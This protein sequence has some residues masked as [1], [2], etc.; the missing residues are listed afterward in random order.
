MEANA[1]NFSMKIIN[2]NSKLNS[3]LYVT[4]PIPCILVVF[5]F[6][7]RS[8]DVLCAYT[9]PHYLQKQY[10]SCWCMYITILLLTSVINYLS[11][12]PHYNTRELIYSKDED[13]ELDSLF[14]FPNSSFSW[15]MPLVKSFA[16]FVY[17]FINFP[18]KVTYIFRT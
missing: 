12:L 4:C 2:H 16:K 6:L 14:F 5:L 8:T 1:Y 17:W 9:K 18:Y 10:F 3:Y 13:A 11:V 7:F 15:Y